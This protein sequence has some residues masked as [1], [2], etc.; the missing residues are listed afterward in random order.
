MSETVVHN[1]GKSRYEIFVDG[2]LAGFTHY[3]LSNGVARFDHTEVQPRFNGR[4]L[5]TTLVKGA[6]DEVRAAGQWKI[7][8]VCPFVAIFVKRHPEY[9]DLVVG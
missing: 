5:G 1:Q 3:D 2:E 9:D 6:F 7:R 8:A 4:G